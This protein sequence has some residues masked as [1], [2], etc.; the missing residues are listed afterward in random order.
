MSPKDVAATTGLTENNA[1]QRLHHLEQAGLIRR[2][3]RGQYTL[4]APPSSP[5]RES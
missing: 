2:V 4:I 1:S 5:T 3:Q